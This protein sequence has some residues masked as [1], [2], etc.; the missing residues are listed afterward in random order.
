M[1]QLIYKSAIGI[2]IVLATTISATAQ[3]LTKSPYSIIGVGDMHFLGTSQQTALGQVG[4][5]I[6][7]SAEVNV[8][9]PASFS[10]LKLTVIEGGL[11]YGTGTLNQ[12]TQSSKITN[13]SFSYFM[14]GIPLHSRL[15]WGLAFGLSPYSNIGYNISSQRAFTDYTASE[16]VEGTGGLSRFHWGTGIKLVKNLSLGINMSYLFGQTSY[17]L[18]HIIPQPSNKFNIAETRTRNISGRQWQVGLQYHKDSIF[19]RNKKDNYV[20]VIGATYTLGAD[21]NARQSQ[22]VRSMGVGATR[23]TLDSIYYTNGVTGIVSM[24]YA[25]ATGL[26]LEKKDKWFAAADFNYTEWSSY[27]SFGRVDSLRNSFGVS[28]GFSMVPKSTDYKHYYNRV[29]YR[30]GGRYDKGNLF[31]NGTN[32]STYAISGGFGLPLGVKTKSRLNLTGEYMV[33]GSLE[34]NLIQE[35][36]FRIIL[37]INFSDKWFQRYKYD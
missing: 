1:Q 14:F 2:F 28:C 20:L 18:K 25:L 12:N 13:S 34:N 6:R 7:K 35:R 22:L 24:P 30:I 3:N 10:G 31:I 33:R 5:G 21:L 27:Q 9:N 11:T 29:E 16:Q 15:G 8:L 23:G 17:E 36:Y 26:S 37:G 19:G 32:I 4:Q